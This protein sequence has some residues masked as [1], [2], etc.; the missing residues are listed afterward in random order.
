[1]S[2]TFDPT[3][4]LTYRYYGSML[5]IDPKAKITDVKKAC[6]LFFDN[7]HRGEKRTMYRGHIIVQYTKVLSGGPQFM[8][9]VYAF[10][11]RCSDTHMLD[12]DGTDLKSAKKAIDAKLDTPETDPLT[13]G[14]EVVEMM[15]PVKVRAAVFRD[16]KGK[17]TGVEADKFIQI[18]SGDR[19]QQD[20][21]GDTFTSEVWSRLPDEIRK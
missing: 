12:V 16:S 13:L 1:M 14:Y 6:P 4:Y 5:Y 7:S 2:D 20:N 21:P 15:V 17:V 9:N 11:V 3:G 18:G 10:D 8:M 19:R